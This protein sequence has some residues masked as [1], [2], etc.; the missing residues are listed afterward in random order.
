MIHHAITRLGAAKVRVQRGRP[1]GNSQ[2]SVE[3][4]D[5]KKEESLVGS[6]IESIQFLP[7]HLSLD[8]PKTEISDLVTRLRL[9]QQSSIT[10]DPNTI[11]GMHFA[12][13]D[14]ASSRTG[15]TCKFPVQVST[16]ETQQCSISRMEPRRKRLGVA[17]GPSWHTIYYHF[18]AT[19]NHPIYSLRIRRITLLGRR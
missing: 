5:H 6:G 1:R 13:I 3:R 17:V 19:N 12:D 10:Q 16:V 7:V 15:G 4:S 14:I 18:P 2:P 8:V 9:F 11:S